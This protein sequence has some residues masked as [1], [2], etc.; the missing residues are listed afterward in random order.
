MNTVLIRVAEEP[1][2]DKVRTT[3]R[4]EAIALHLSHAQTTVTTSSLQGLS[5]KHGDRA[6][7]PAVNLVVDQMLQALVKGG[8]NENTCIQKSPS[9]ALI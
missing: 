7:G 9:V 5:G 4:D 1:V 2:S 6:A 3:M 8:A